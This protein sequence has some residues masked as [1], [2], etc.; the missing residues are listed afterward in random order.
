MKKEKKQFCFKINSFYEAKKT[1]KICIKHKIVPVIYISYYMIDGFG[2]NWLIEFKNLLHKQYN[3]NDFKFLV[4]C[5]Q[6][7]G[8]F[9]SLANLKIHFLNVNGN[10]NTLL[11]LEQIAKKNKISI[12]P[13][14]DILKL[15]KIKNIEKKLLK[16]QNYNE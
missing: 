14:F 5:K 7:Y 6:N 11:R 15:K 13:K 16:L 9:I 8:L 2:V 3:K 12:N 1:I 10:K 4:S